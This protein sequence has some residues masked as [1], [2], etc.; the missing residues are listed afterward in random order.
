MAGHAPRAFA[1]RMHVALVVLML[2]SFALIAQQRVKAL[3]QVGFLVLVASTF[4]Q[5]V[6]GNI[7]PTVGFARSMKQ[8]AL[9]LAIIAAVFALGAAVTPVLV[10]LGR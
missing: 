1:S 3:Y 5:I 6:F 8:L 4:A 2:A 9:G 7:A 10:N